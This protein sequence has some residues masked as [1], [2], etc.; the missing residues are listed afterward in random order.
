MGGGAMRAAAKIFG[1]T[2]VNSGG[3]IR[4][5]TTSVPL[6]EHSVTNAARKVLKPGSIL[7]SS[8]VIDDGKTA[9]VQSGSVQR[10]AWQMID[11][12]EFADGEEDGFLLDSMNPKPR[13]VFEGVPC[14][15]E[16][17]EATDDLKEAL[18]KVYLNF[19][20]AT[21]G[22]ESSKV[23]QDS[24]MSTPLSSSG[25][26]ET[27]ACVTSETAVIHPS[28][29]KPAFQ[30]F[31]L[32]KESPQ[33]QFVVASLVS[34]EN[35]WNAVRKNEQ[36]MEFLKLQRA[37]DLLSD[38]VNDVNVENEFQ[39][40]QKSK[41]ASD[42]KHS[43]GNYDNIFTKIV[44]K[45]KATVVEMVSNLSGLF[46]DIF[47]GGPTEEEV[48]IDPNGGATIV[49]KTMGASLM[50]LAVLAIMVVLFKRN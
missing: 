34:D 3:A 33:A 10:P 43:K 50:G 23:I 12:W 30:A 9:V 41:G 15:D 44:K 46:H 20:N 36:L 22:G 37:G 1:V 16:A 40:D 13:I 8:P 31:S 21:D 24:T 25:Y 7:S 48:K 14:L 27:K 32:L 6:P 49:D 42:E 47:V 35:V 2:S 26:S 4:G 18:E 28:V 17:K 38:E 39:D 19:P 29:S 11:D 45:V 5:A